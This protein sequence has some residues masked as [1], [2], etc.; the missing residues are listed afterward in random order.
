MYFARTG[1]ISQNPGRISA[2][3]RLYWTLDLSLQKGG[4]CRCFRPEANCL[5]NLSWPQGGSAEKRLQTLRR[6]SDLFL[7]GA[8]RFSDEQIGVFDD[9]LVHLINKIETKA[10]IELSARLLIKGS[11][12]GLDLKEFFLL[13]SSTGLAYRRCEL[14]RID[15]EQIGARF[16]QPGRKKATSSLSKRQHAESEH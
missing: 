11:I 10:L 7:G 9:V 5:T 14:A 4:Y 13:L 2:T 8:V 12:A 1:R 6:V 15:G 16:L 3:P